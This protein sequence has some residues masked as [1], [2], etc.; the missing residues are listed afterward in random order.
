MIPKPGK[1]NNNNKNSTKLQA[2]LPMNTDVK[3][4]YKILADQIHRLFTMIKWDS[5]QECKD[6][7]TYAR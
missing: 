5:Y 6:G 4:L 3:I 7:S 2:I 1:Q